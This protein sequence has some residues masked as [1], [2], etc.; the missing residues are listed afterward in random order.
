MK[1]LP[2]CFGIILCLPVSVNAQASSDGTESDGTEVVLTSE[3]QW[4]QLNPARGD[5]SPQAANIWG[6]RKQPGETGFLVPEFDF[7]LMGRRIA[8]LVKSKDLIKTHGLA[9]R[10][11]IKQLCGGVR[12]EQVVLQILNKT[13]R[14]YRPD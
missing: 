5:A 9:G 3:I 8:E 4:E 6:D 7:E 11:R 2:L 14:E 13:S 1:Y 10:V 12:R